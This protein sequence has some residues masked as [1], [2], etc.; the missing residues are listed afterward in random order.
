MDFESSK[1]EANASRLVHTIK[2][3]IGSGT[4]DL[5]IALFDNDT[6]GMKEIE[7]LKKIQFPENIKVLQYPEIELAKK[8]PTLGPTGIQAMDV[9]G[10]ACSIEMYLGKDVLTEAN[11]FIPVKWTGLVEKMDKYQGVV[12]KKKE[13]Q[14]RFRQKVKETYSGTMLKDNWK[15]LIQILE[16][17]NNTWK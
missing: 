9:N 17:M 14:K 8:Y 6:A 7:N 3:F 1:C 15:E 2:S 12:L 16:L 4:R 5:I 11:G 13:I 10:L